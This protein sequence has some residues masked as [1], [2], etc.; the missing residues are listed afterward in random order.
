MVRAIKDNWRDN[1]VVRS[2]EIVT[3]D[4]NL[5][6]DI[7]QQRTPLL[8]HI[9]PVP[10]QLIDT[11]D[12]RL[13][14]KF[15]VLK[16]QPAAPGQAEQPGTPEKWVGIGGL[17]SICIHNNFGFG[18][19]EDVHLTINGVLAETAQREYGRTSYLK[20]LL[21]SNSTEKRMLESAFFYEDTPGQVDSVRFEMGDPSANK[22]VASRI[23]AIQKGYTA[24]F[25]APIYLDV[26]QAGAY[27]PDH[28][29][30]TLHL[31]PSNPT[32]CVIYDGDAPAPTIKIELLEAELHVPR[33]QLSIATPKQF[34]V[35]YES[36]KVLSYVNPKE[37][38]SFSRS[39]NISQLPK[40]LAMVV[41]SENQ[42][43]GINKPSAINFKNHDVKT[44]RVRCNGQTYPTSL[45]MTMDYEKEEH[46]QAYMA[47]FSQLNAVDPHFGVDA[48]DNGYA[49]YGVDLPPGH[50]RGKSGNAVGY[51]TCDVDIDFAKKPSENL[52]ILIFC[53]YDSQFSFD[54]RGIVHNS[55]EVKL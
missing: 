34:S 42:Y 31:Y 18:V 24:S 28:V 43:H 49:I 19:F 37:V 7:G 8:F 40:K 20:N 16:L 47:L 9:R 12:I 23:L 1:V 33:C 32:K 45:G 53:F 26:L 36:V 51:G 2:T 17:D 29:G 14:V 4:T 35:P 39:L 48:F 41:L 27:F 55:A 46:K 10:N 22:G 38:Q 54:G 52:V 30:F 3:C 50:K 15:R 13:L 21:F 25:I 11:K 5:P 44:V 6:I